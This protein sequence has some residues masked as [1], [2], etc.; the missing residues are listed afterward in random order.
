MKKPTIMRIL[1]LQI[2]GLLIG[3]GLGIALH[4]ENLVA[5][6]FGEGFALGCLLIAKWNK[7]TKNGL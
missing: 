3:L 5:A 6:M 2:P 1:L 4:G 7:A